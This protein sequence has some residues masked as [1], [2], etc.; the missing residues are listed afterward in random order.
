MGTR[1]WF[2]F[3][4]LRSSCHLL[5]AAFWVWIIFDQRLGG[6]RRG[7]FY[8]AG[9]GGEKSECLDVKDYRCCL[10]PR[11]TWASCVSNRIFTMRCHSSESFF[12]LHLSLPSRVAISYSTDHHQ[13]TR[14]SSRCAPSKSQTSIADRW[15]TWLLE[16]PHLS[17]SIT[18]QQSEGPVSLLLQHRHTAS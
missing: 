15:E 8:R 16:S 4:V 12:F 3:S 2:S 14:T 5:A 6:A 17:C 11:Y 13:I 18:T 10:K 9:A 7:T 1:L